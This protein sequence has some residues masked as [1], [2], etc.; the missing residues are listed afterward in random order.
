[1]YSGFMDLR[2]LLLADYANI[3]IHN[4]I[5]VMGIM[6]HINSKEFPAVH[7]EMFLVMRFA[8]SPAEF[9]QTRKLGVN[10]M[11]EDGK[12]MGG[13]IKSF[14]I[15]TPT[16]IS[17]NNEINQIF[18]LTNTCFSKPG[19]YQFSILIDQDEKGHY[20]LVVTQTDNDIPS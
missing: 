17:A 19:T 1:M 8:I 10:L 3:E 5:N 12:T 4:K 16:K 20:P 11:D 6:N 18:R 13:L 9:G 7:P 15:P 14:E 2:V